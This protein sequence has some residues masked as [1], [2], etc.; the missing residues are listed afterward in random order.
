[1]CE[2]GVIGYAA[3]CDIG[4]GRLVIANRHFQKAQNLVELLINQGGFKN[5]VAQALA[6]TDGSYANMIINC[7]SLGL[8]PD[9]SLPIKF[10]K[11]SAGTV[12]AD[13][14]MMPAKTKW[15]QAAATAGLPIHYGHH[16]LDHQ[17][18]LIGK[19]IGAL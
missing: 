11:V 14:I 7:T 5:V 18:E 16:M 3:V 17:V 10:Q 4:V 12:I 6:D 15:L 1:M 13:I 2:R 8:H 19:F 9:D